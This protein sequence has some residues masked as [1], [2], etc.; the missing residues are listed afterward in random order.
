MI[1]LNLWKSSDQKDPKMSGFTRLQEDPLEVDASAAR[2]YGST[3]NSI[4]R[5]HDGD[6]DHS[7]DED[8]SAN[9]APRKGN[10]FVIILAILSGIGGFLFGYDTGVVSGALLLLGEDFSLTTFQKELFVSITIGFAAIFALISGLLND[11]FGR[12][13]IICVASITFAIGAIV[14]GASMDFSILLIGRA[15]VGIGIGRP[16]CQ[17]LW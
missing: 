6:T 11:K 5:T 13:I 4:D 2:E 17:Y 15:V 16:N 12:K 3:G 1:N 9:V 14:L 7:G 10:M 8:F